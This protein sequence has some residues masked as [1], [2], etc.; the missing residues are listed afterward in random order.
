MTPQ[1][2]AVW[3]WSRWVPRQAP[4]AVNA[5]MPGGAGGE[6]EGEV[7]E[8]P[9]LAARGGGVEVGDAEDDAVVGERGADR[10]DGELGAPDDA[11]DAAL[12]VALPGRVSA[13]RPQLA[14]GLVDAFGVEGAQRAGEDLAVEAD[15]V[16]AAVVPGRV[17][18]VG[19]EEADLAGA[20]DGEVALQ[21][22]Q[23]CSTAGLRRRL[24]K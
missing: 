10:G 4:S 22:D 2:V 17:R 7:G 24:Q 18:G 21:R 9:A 19:V 16:V 5:W 6:V 15:D 23:L 8:H 1:P 12:A 3:I 20:L 14:G 11:V 13:D